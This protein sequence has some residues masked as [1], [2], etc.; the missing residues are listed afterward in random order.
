MVTLI[1][2][3]FERVAGVCECNRVCVVGV[4]PG[5]I[6]CLL[7]S[8]E[9]LGCLTERGVCWLDGMTTCS[10]DGQ[11][12]E[13]TLADE[14]SILSMRVLLALLLVL[15][16]PKPKLDHVAWCFNYIPN[17]VAAQS[18]HCIAPPEPRITFVHWSERL[19]DHIVNMWLT[20]GAE[21]G[22]FWFQC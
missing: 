9:D 20:F 7:P 17:P 12:E 22:R 11:E 1:V 4:R 13:D 19:S 15:H 21:A 10:V 6:W 5:Q 8:E 18:L 14:D 2:G 3:M 16:W